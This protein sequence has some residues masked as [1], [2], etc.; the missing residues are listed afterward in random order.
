MREWSYDFTV[1]T[2]LALGF[3]NLGEV[4]ECIRHYDDDAVSRTIYGTRMGQLTRFE[5]VLI[6]SMGEH[7]ILG[8]PGSNETMRWAGLS[9][10]ALTSWIECGGRAYRLEHIAPSVIQKRQDLA[11]MTWIDLGAIRA[12][13]QAR[14]TL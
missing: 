7:Y 12:L 11:S 4:D 5:Y 14:M 10:T 3:T 6:A 8:I 13:V 9:H 2:L 1:R